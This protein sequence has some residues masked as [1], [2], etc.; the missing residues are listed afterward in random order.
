MASKVFYSL[1]KRK[2]EMFFNS[3]MDLLADKSS[4]D[5]KIEDVLEYTGI[6]RATFYNYFTD[7]NEMYDDFMEFA[8][9]KMFEDAME[10]YAKTKSFFSLA[11]AVNQKG[12]KYYENEKFV[13]ILTNFADANKRIIRI[14]YSERMEQYLSNIMKNTKT[15][16]SKRMNDFS[17]SYTILNVTVYSI[18]ASLIATAFKKKNSS[19][20]ASMFDFKFFLDL[21]KAGHEKMFAEK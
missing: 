10:E 14:I 4:D 12:V 7:I 1:N 13:K 20:S 9:Q 6:S 17:K 16:E 2:I 5:I 3:I 15:I 11:D 18:F 19:L 21:L 8:I